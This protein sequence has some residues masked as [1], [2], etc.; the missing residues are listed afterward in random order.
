MNTS[1]GKLII[2]PASATSSDHISQVRVDGALADAQGIAAIVHTGM[3]DH[4]IP[5]QTEA[6]E[7]RELARLFELPGYWNQADNS[8]MPQFVPTEPVRMDDWQSLCQ[9]FRAEDPYGEKYLP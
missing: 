5:T 1:P 2:E 9:G 6:D 4:I 7:L 8:T 3:N